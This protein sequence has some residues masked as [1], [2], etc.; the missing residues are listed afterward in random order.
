MS[1]LM[2]YL[3][4][5]YMESAEVVMIQNALQSEVDEL[6]ETR[7]DL[8][9]QLDPRTATWGL[10]YWEKAFGIVPDQAKD[11]EYRRSLVVAKIRGNGTTTAALIKEVSESFSNGEVEVTEFPR[12]YRLEIFFSGTMGTPPNM[13]DL[14]AVLDEIIPAHLE[15]AFVILY[16]SHSQMKAFTHGELAAYTHKSIREGDLADG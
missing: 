7:H 4:E 8:L 14:A 10:D 5:S 12:E 9:A 13:D 6:W 11:I 1:Y 15:W 3:P 2:N 16:F